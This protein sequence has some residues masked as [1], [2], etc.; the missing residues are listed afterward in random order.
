MP[1]HDPAA[2]GGAELHQGRGSTPLLLPLVVDALQATLRLQE[3][4]EELS[5][6]LS[7]F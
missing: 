5:I 3:L 2:S 6:R 7:G 4:L 1:D